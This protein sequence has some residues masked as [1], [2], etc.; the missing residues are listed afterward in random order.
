MSYFRAQ[1]SFPN[2]SYIVNKTYVAKNFMNFVVDAIVLLLFLVFFSSFHG[3][4]FSDWLEL[5]N[6][7]VLVMTSSTPRNGMVGH[8]CINEFLL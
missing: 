6:F 8:F 5:C 7:F 4:K 2:E 1:N 3:T